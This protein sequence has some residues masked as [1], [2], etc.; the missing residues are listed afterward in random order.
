MRLSEVMAGEINH[1]VRFT[2]NNTSQGYIQPATHAA[3]QSDMTLPP[4]GLR[5]RLKASFDL[6]PF[7]GATLVV[8]TA[9]K[10]YGILLADNGSDWYIS[11]ESND[12]WAPLMDDLV[13]NI[14][15][16]T[17]GD[18]EVVDTGPV[19]TAGL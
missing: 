19:S 18:F 5:L 1:A 2:M 6:S 3:G 4:M 15:K 9:M 16:V 8:F 11:G 13:G 10:K 17:G 14:Q 7:S 12:G